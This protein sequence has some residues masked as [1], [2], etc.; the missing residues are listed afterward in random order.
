MID[1]QDFWNPFLETLPP[2]KLAEIE[3]KNFRRYL[4][5]AKEHSEFYRKTLAGIERVISGAKRTSNACQ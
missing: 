2:E 3:L 4:Q 5:Y 1:R